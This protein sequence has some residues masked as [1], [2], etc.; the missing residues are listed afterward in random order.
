M[1]ERNCFNISNVDK[2][3]VSFDVNIYGLKLA[4]RIE[5]FQ[6]ELHNLSPV[7]NVLSTVIYCMCAHTHTHSLTHTG[8]HM[9]MH[10]HAKHM[11]NTHTHTLTGMYMYMHTNAKRQTHAH[12]HTHTHS[13]T[14]TQSLAIFFIRNKIPN[15]YI[16]SYLIIQSIQQECLLTKWCTFCMMTYCTLCRKTVSTGCVE[17][18]LQC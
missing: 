15:T 16:Y 5:Q 10:T 17:H 12:T 6:L 13:H 3:V 18:G 8:M 11:S 14:H 2:I 4:R 1:S 7:V 9:Y